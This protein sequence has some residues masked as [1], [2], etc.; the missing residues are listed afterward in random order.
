MAV[1][2]GA[3][4]RKAAALNLRTAAALLAVAQN[5]VR[6]VDE[7]VRETANGGPASN[8]TASGSPVMELVGELGQTIS[9]AFKLSNPSTSAV[10]VTP[11]VQAE[12]AAAEVR[13][14]P[15]SVTVE[16]GE[17]VVIRVLADLSEA[18]DLGRS[19]AGAVTVPGLST[20]AIGFVVRRVAPEAHDRPA[21][22]T[23]EIGRP[24]LIDERSA[25]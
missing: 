4:V 16:P 15:E 21:R 11:R 3:V 13:L 12:G 19:Y 18:F 23:A 5:Y 22:L 17:D 7:L 8:P 14:E 6:A 20:Q 9:S 1:R 25:G 2:L 24:V 10:A